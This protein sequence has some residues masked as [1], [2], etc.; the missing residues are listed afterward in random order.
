MGKQPQRRMGG[1][2]WKPGEPTLTVSE[3]AEALAPIAPDVAGTV[4]RIRHWTRERALLPVDQ[5]HAGPGKHRRYAGDAVYVAAV[6]HAL[7][8]AGF[9]ISHSRFLTDAV[10]IVR[11]KLVDWMK[12][13]ERGE[14]IKLPPLVL[15]VTAKGMTAIVAEKLTDELLHGFKVEDVVLKMEID[16]NRLFDRLGEAGR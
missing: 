7:T 13:R 9:P 16:L 8:I 5:H 3:I 1:P 15:G 10:T 14:K 11:W 12:A 6:L 2:V 4:Q